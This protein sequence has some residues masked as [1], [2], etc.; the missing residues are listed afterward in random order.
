VTPRVVFADADLLVVDKPSGMPSVPARTPLDPADVATR[1]VAEFG[2]TEAVHRLDRDTSGLLVLARNRA[3]RSALGRAFERRDVQKLYLAVV[4]GRPPAAAGEIRLPLAADPT[5]PPRQRIDHVRGKPA[6]SRW[7]LVEVRA[8]D[9]TST[10]VRCL[11]AVEPLTGRSHQIRVHLASLGCPV[12][13]DRL[14]DEEACGPTTPHLALHALAITFPHPTTA[15]R[16]ALV[17]P[18]APQP[19]WGEFKAAIAAVSAAWPSSPPSAN[20]VRSDPD[21]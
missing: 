1:L 11:L 15:A 20:T 16:L 18:P 19:P 6:T 2:A 4:R 5:R 21:R 7:R 17:A 9:S 8:T 14:Y 13:G 12:A 10:A 3:A